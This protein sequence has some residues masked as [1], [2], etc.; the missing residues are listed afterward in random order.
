MK[1]LGLIPV[2]A[3]VGM[4]LCFTTLSAQAPLYN[5]PIRG[6]P[7]SR[8]GEGIRGPGDTRPAVFVLAPNH[9]GFTTQAQPEL[10]WYLSQDSSYPIEVILN[11]ETGIEP[12]FETV[13][14]PPIKAGIHH[15]QLATHRIRLQPDSFYEWFIAVVTG[16]D[17]PSQSIVSGG[18]DHLHWPGQLAG[19]A[20]GAS[21]QS[22]AEPSGGVASLCRLR[23]LVRCGVRPLETDP[24]NAA[25][26]GAAT[27]KSDLAQRGRLIRDSGR[28]RAASLE[29]LMIM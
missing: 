18:G 28:S 22:C 29:R 21:A 20:G 7:A 4:L 13:L 2:W 24:T 16:T 12:I 26:V 8:V 5:P 1:T 23:H 9:V 15:V 25:G 10:Y 3:T 17:A 19:S 11:D 14:S 6:A 27:T